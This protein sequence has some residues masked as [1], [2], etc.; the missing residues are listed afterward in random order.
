MIFGKKTQI[1]PITKKDEEKIE[2]LLNRGVE[3]ILPS[4]DFLR[5]KLK[6]GQRLKIYTGIDPTGPFLHLGHS[7]WLEKLRQFQDLGHEIVL[8]IGGFTATIGDPTGKDT[9]RKVLT[10]NEV[11]SNAKKY[12]EQ[13]AKILNFKGKN[14]AKVL[15]NSKWL[16]KMNFSDI[17]KLSSLITV[18]QLLKRDMF[19]KRVLEGKPIYLHEF[20][21]ALMQ[22]YDSVILDVDVEVGG[23]DQLFNML[24][25]RDFQKKINNKEKFVL[26]MKLLTDS[27][28][29]KM[30]KSEGNMVTLED[31]PNEMYGK[32]MSWTDSMIVP[33]FELCTRI[34]DQDLKNISDDLGRTET[35]PRDVKMKLA[36]EVVSLYY[37]EHKALSA[38]KNFTQTFQKH[39]L[40]DEIQTVSVVSGELLSKILFENNLIDSVGEFKRLVKEGAVNINENQKV[41]SFSITIDQ[42]VTVKVGKKRFLKIN[43]K[44]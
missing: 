9:A 21:Y 35:N 41:D 42:D 44:R 36:H 32:V 22:G 10:E 3:Q 27:S 4:V 30:G 31:G 16:K 23:N 5:S 7:I 34:T 29:K 18:D 6:S 19:E 37:D 17:L 24:V 1:G 13:A 8:L 12:V 28:G 43:I 11:A 39:Q 33:G 20:M 2:H 40:P 38:G 25:G 14:P 26:T 15:N